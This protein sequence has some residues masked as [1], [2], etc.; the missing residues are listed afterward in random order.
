MAFPAR[1][2]TFKLENCRDLYNKLQRE[3]DRFKKDLTDPLDRADHAFNVVI[4]AWHLC[5]WVHAGLTSELRSKLKIR[6][7]K[8]MQ[9]VARECRALH[10]CEQ[11]ATASKHWAVFEEY[12][13]PK[14]STIVA[15]APAR[16]LP[17]DIYR[18][19]KFDILFKDGDKLIEAE[20]VFDEA[21][22]FWTQF[23][24]QNKICADE[25]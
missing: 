1:E 19:P 22:D 16:K 24:Y 17:D 20:T 8:D 6:S 23:I 14:V 5:D 10:L 3:I 7:R 25:H 2:K 4:T 12:R 15:I 9:A 18:P 21:L 13:D 11:A